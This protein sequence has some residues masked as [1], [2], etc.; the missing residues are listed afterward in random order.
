MTDEGLPQVVPH[1]LPIYI[2]NIK[3]KISHYLPRKIKIEI[4]LKSFYS[5]GIFR[6]FNCLGIYLHILNF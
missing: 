2:Q 5:A 4:S 6:I 3:S 1:T